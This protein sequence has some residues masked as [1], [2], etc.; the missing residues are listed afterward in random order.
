MLTCLRSVVFWSGTV[1]QYYPFQ[2]LL[3][4][5]QRNADGEI[6]PPHRT[7]ESTI[8]RP[9]SSPSVGRKLLRSPWCR[10]PL[11]GRS[12]RRGC[13]DEN[14]Q[15]AELC[16]SVWDKYPLVGARRAAER[17]D[18][19]RRRSA[20]SGR[21]VKRV[22][23]RPGNHSALA[24]H[25]PPP[26]PHHTATGMHLE[27]PSRGVRRRGNFALIGPVK[28]HRCAAGICARPPAGLLRSHG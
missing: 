4:A 24:S 20:R 22:R 23:S 15:D 19:R 27:T 26:R 10:R 16:N 28:R 18:W 12:A 8:Y 14:R 2:M 11:L 5:H 13:P 21:G 17:Q 25:T 7:W 6:S 9:P 3:A 1:S